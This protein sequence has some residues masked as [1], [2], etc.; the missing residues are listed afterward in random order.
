[1]NY[2]IPN[3]DPIIDK[4]DIE[5]VV[6]ALKKK[7]LSQGE[8]IKEFEKEF[9]QYAGTKEAVA[10]N[11]GTAALHV[12]LA[13]MGIKSGDEVIT[14][15]FTFAATANIIVL[16]GAKPVF[17]D[18]TL[19]TYNINPIEIEKKITERTKA[20]VPVHYAGQCADMDEI[21][22]IA[23]EHEIFVLEDAA[24]AHGALYK[25]RK[26]GSLGHAAAFSFYPNKNM[27]TGEGGMLTTNNEEFAEKARILAN[28]GQDSRYHHVKIGWNYK[29]PDYVAALGRVQLKRL[30]Y[31]INKKNQ[32]GEYY[33]SR[34][35]DFDGIYPPVTRHFNKHTYMLYPIRTHTNNLREK[36]KQ[37]LEEKGVE[38][39]ICFPSVHLQPVYMKRFG[40][41]PRDY[42]L[43]EL[44]SDTILCLPI[45][46]RLQ[47]EKQ[48]FILEIIEQT[49]ESM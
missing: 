28:H 48:E 49:K 4:E 31:C 5:A 11:S 32:I 10:L 46:A 17:A 34:L 20:I 47:R 15:P 3:A 6:E 35:K 40:F 19:D 38:T 13:A 41:K 21:M 24:E 8:Y 30:D 29:M 25:D 7:R 39:R 1:M 23:E 22:E 27:T 18:I 12:G 26:A 9:A 16:L 14:T 43:S 44:A 45:F 33:T 2:D 37:N 36:L 42:P